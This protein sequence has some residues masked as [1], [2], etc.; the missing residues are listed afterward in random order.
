MFPLGSGPPALGKTR[1]LRGIVVTSE[2]ACSSR[3]SPERNR[4]GCRASNA[5]CPS[6]SP[7]APSLGVS[8]PHSH[9]ERESSGRSARQ[10]PANTRQQ[11]HDAAFVARMGAGR[12]RLQEIPRGALPGLRSP[13]PKEGFGW[14][15]VIWCSEFPDTFLVPWEYSCPKEK[16]GE[17]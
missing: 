5:F 14:R 11:L 3:A 2:S 13:G 6:V 4:S 16:N 9:W 10:S 17:L 8:C 7:W 1:P 15:K 12:S